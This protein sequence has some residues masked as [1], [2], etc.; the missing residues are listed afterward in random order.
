MISPLAM[1]EDQQ[2]DQNGQFTPGNTDNDV[3]AAV[4]AHE[5]AATSEVAQE[6]GLTRQGADHRL[7]QLRDKGRIESKKIA[8]SLVWYVADDT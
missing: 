7:R 3:V 6:L 2:R 4:R 1:G 5:P 8:A